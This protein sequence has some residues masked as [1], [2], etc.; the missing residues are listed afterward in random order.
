MAPLLVASGGSV[1]GV[2]TSDDIYSAVT[3]SN[4]SRTRGCFL[5]GAGMHMII[6]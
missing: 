4:T 5:G 3:A 1:E 2:A 6:V